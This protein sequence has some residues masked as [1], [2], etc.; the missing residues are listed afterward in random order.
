[1][2]PAL[3]NAGQGLQWLRR[4]LARGVSMLLLLG[5]AA[6]A[7]ATVC[8]PQVPP[9]AAVPRDRGL[10]W[11]ITRDGHS[12]W[13][14]GTLHVGKPAWRGF[15]PHLVAALQ[16][17]D[18]LALEIDPDDP[19]LAAALADTGPPPVLPPALKARLAR[20]YVQACVAPEAMAGL[21]PVLQATTLTVLD[22]RWLGMDA[23][24]AQEQL[25]LK[26]MRALG[27]PVVALETPAQQRAALVPT[28][29][30]EAR[31][32]LDQTLAQLEDGSG[33][34]VLAHMARAWAAGDLQ[35]L[36]HYDRWCECSNGQGERDFMRHLN[37]DRNPALA[38]G[39][40]A[41][42][43]RGL[44]VFAAVGALHMTGPQ[45]LPRLL[46]ERGFRVERVRFGP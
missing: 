27:H 1:M 43:A 41:L 34:R 45:S 8:P 39:I 33:R 9:A 35:T 44:R 46:R 18:V 7:A 40:A 6:A 25:L 30:A 37:D 42:H 21:H 15:G 32:V 36:E 20:A 24:D 31:A 14:F 26:R 11:R 22:A 29:P 38:D 17:S 13:L 4:Q 19:A 5:L 23:N 2:A 3:H 16:A 28:D 12:S 10:L